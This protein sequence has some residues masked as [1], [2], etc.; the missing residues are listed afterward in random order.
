MRP[1]LL[2]GYE[3]WSLPDED[4]CPLGISD[5]RC[6][7]SIAR[8]GWSDRIQVR[9]RVLDAGSE[10]ILS[11]HMKS[12]RLRLLIIVLHSTKHSSTI[13]WSVLRSSRGVEEAI[14]RSAH[15]LAV[16]NETVKIS[17]WKKIECL[18]SLW[19]GSKRLTTHFHG[20]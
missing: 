20:A 17:K 2:H 14:W 7:Q 4:A 5:R 16:C 9:S 8:A 6:S 11:Q 19:L 18:V 12:I 3:A 1:V 10:N 13:S 15:E